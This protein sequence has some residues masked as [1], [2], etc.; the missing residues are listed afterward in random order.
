MNYHLFLSTKRTNQNKLTPI[1][2]KIKIDGKVYERSTGVFIQSSNWNSMY[3]RVLPSAF[4]ALEG[5]RKIEDFEAK[6]R[7]LQSVTPIDIGFVDRWLSN[8][9]KANNSIPYTLTLVMDAF[10]EHKQ[11]LVDKSE[12]IS[13]E[14]YRTYLAKRKNID[15]YLEYSN[16][17][18]LRIDDLT[19]TKGESIKAYLYERKFG[20]DHV[21]KHLRFLR[22]VI[23]FAQYEY[24]IKPSNFMLLKIK[25]PQLKPIVY[26]TDTELETLQKHVFLSGLHQKAADIFLLQCFTGMAYCDVIKLS[27]DYIVNYEGNKFINYS[28][29]KT[30]VNGLVPVL[31]Q[32]NKILNRYDGKAPVLCN[33]L[34][35]RILKEI[36][37]CCNITKTLTSHVGRKTFGCMLLSKGASMETTTKMLA[38]T[39]VRETQRIYAEVQWKRLLN[40]MPSF[41]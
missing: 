37:A 20:A 21:N 28:R 30:G 34:Y 27:Y 16:Q 8:E 25:E 4:G 39:N 18:L 31:P 17:K 3:K 9:N 10:F 22:A 24:G 23:K 29:K 6:L 40:E 33:Q 1:Y 32:V 2:A 26:L 13:F 35:N 7:F 11:L 5:N 15:S 36:A 14:T 41:G 38:K 12:G 19:Y